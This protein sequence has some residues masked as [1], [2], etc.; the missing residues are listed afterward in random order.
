[1][2]T[3][4]T[5]GPPTPGAMPAG[6]PAKKSNA[7]LWIL[8]GCGTFIVLCIVIFVGLFFYGMHKVKQ[9]GLDPELMKKNPPLAAA[10]IVIATNPEL[11]MV[12]SDDDNGTMVV[13]EKKTGK[14]VTMKFDPAKKKMVIV[15]EKG[16]ESTISA[17]TDK[18][19]LE[20]KTD[21]GTMKMGATADKPPDWV[22][23]YPGVTPKNTYSM[24]DGKEQS[25]TY[26]FTTSDS[27]EKVMG[28]YA[29]QLKSGGLKVTNT[30]TT[31][32][33]KVSGMVSG[34]DAAR[35]RTVLVTAHPDGDGTGVSVTF[36][37]KK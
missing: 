8:G 34:E 24:S 28:F 5:G 23:I 13:R 12:S 17:D 2:S 19:S 29:D 18:G 20:I 15:D 6:V 35:D 1:M 30:S 3:T 21:E 22:P 27:S 31:S 36:R 32:D 4:P 33:G 11:E 37:A 16:K 14:T 9:A 26:V 7:L 10:K 25:G